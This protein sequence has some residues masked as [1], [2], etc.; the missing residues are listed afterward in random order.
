MY[1][2]A[3]GLTRLLAPILSITAE[4][5]WAQLPG[6]REASVHLARLPARTPTS[7]RDDALE[8][9]VDAAARGPRRSVNAA[10]ERRAQRKEIG[11]AARRRT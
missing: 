2:I 5:I 7:W 8:T 9:R 6:A 4:E 3:D 1:V 10:L 11:S